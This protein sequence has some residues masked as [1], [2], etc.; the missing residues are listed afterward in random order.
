MKETFG[1]KDRAEA[2]ALHRAMIIGALAKAQLA[3]GELAAELRKLSKKR[4]RRPGDKVSRRYG[5][6]TL[7]RWLYNLMFPE[8]RGHPNKR[9][10]IRAGGPHGRE[11]KTKKLHGG[12]QA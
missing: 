5:V 7:E 1:P 3:H 6:S 12:V 11:E 9:D 8:F 4:F 10:T 2:I